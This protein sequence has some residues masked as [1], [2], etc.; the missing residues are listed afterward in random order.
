MARSVRPFACR[1]CVLLTLIL[2]A[3]GPALARAETQTR[4][5]D[6]RVVDQLGGRLAGA[7]VVL[8]QDEVR[9]ASLHTDARGAFSFPV[10][11]D[12]RYRLEAS[13]PGFGASRLPPFFVGGTGRADIEIVLS[14]GPIAEQAVVSAAAVEVPRSRVGASVSVIDARDLE[15]SGAADLFEMLRWV[16]GASV[17][18]TGARGG[19]TSL[20]LRGGNAGFAK[21]VIDGVPVNEIGGAFD[22]AGLQTT[23]VERVEVLRGPNSV[24]YGADALTGVVTVTTARGRTRRP[25]FTYATEGGSF[26]TV[27]HVTSVGGARGRVE[28]YSAYSHVGTDNA[29]PNS[30]FAN[31][32]YAGRFG[33]TVGPSTDLGLV[34]R[35]T[36]SDQG[37]PN[38]VDYFGLSDDSTQQTALTTV[39]VSARSRL[40]RRL[41]SDVRFSALA[42]SLTL[43]N[44]SPTGEPFDPF[45]YGAS[46]LG[47]PVTIRGANGT[48]ATG[49][50]VLD[51]GGVYPSRYQSEGQRRSFHGQVDFDAGPGFGIA[52]GLRVDA[53]RGTSTSGTV[54]ST[55]RQDVGGF[56]EVRTGVGPVFV[57]GGL[58]LDHH[59]VFRMSVT[60]RVSVAAYLRTP[61][62]AA[63]W[64]TTKVTF[65][66]GK[67]VKA[68]SLLQELSSLY[69]VAQ[70]SPAAALLVSPLRP[71]TSVG[72]D[73]GLEQSVWGGRV[74][75]GATWFD[76][77]F[78]DLIEYVGATALARLGVADAAITAASY[79]AYVN[80]QAYRARGLETSVEVALSDALDVRTTY[81]LLSTRVTESFASS[82]LEPSTN[83]AYPDRP[84][85][86]YA[87]LVGG[88]AFRRPA[89]SGSVVVTYA[90][91]RLQ[92]LGSATLAG[93][94][95]DST[96]L[97]DAYFGSSLL[98]PNRDLGARVRR[99]DARVAYT[100]S[101]R[102]RAFV[103]VENL[104]DAPY[105]A[106]SGY[107]GLRR[108]AR[109][110]LAMALG[111]DRSA[112][113]P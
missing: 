69:T 77:R 9:V 100:V 105:Q 91:G 50:A 35:R 76:N 71:E 17:Q 29:V 7:E 93:R 86:A 74:R 14:V 48:T 57:N 60:P 66:A 107:P 53:E 98:L 99:V 23:G 70:A 38:A 97:S 106:A 44:P 112:V 40:T 79:G 34:V 33:V 90:A 31:D 78:R 87:P 109:A 45:G 55:R 88:R 82:A 75:L 85:G 16:P 13:A 4:S 36:S 28:Y 92:V 61:S 108:A 12:G 113:S 81:A 18:Q 1:L 64:G 52:G 59:T 63:R 84:I 22:F 104:L 94:Y 95:D 21:V 3:A 83:P 110:G 111:G 2:V 80:A 26:G 46:Y 73:A 42:Q 39:S 49:Q 15:G 51:F 103:A 47:R 20:F 32:T 68:P 89:H 19:V 96:F 67:G 72:L 41:T 102:V 8:W 101:P 10:S 6:G 65:N 5:I 27:R 58:G 54:S 25:A 62:P 11:D 56:V 37:V 24:L 43:T 30:Q